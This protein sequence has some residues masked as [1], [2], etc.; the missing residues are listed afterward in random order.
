MVLKTINDCNLLFKTGFFCAFQE[1][2]RLGQD[3]RTKQPFY[4]LRLRV[5]FT[6]AVTLLLPDTASHGPTPRA[7]VP[8]PGMS[9]P[10]RWIVAPLSSTFFCR[11]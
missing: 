4:R 9:G 10:G 5:L 8:A 2:A 11:Y 6:S 3:L 1:V 7:G